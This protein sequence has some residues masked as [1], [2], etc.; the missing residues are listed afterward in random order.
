MNIPD[1]Y[2]ATQ[3]IGEV[4]ERYIDGDEPFPRFIY[5]HLPND[6]MAAARPEDGYPYAESFVAD[7]DY[8]LGRI[9]EFLSRTEWWPKMA[10]F[11]TEDDAQ[12]GRDHVDAHRTVLIAAGPYVKRN[13]VSHVN[14]SFPGLLKT[15]FRILDLPPLNLFDATAS[16]LTDM[17]SSEP[18]LSPYEA[19]PVDARLFIPEEARD[20]LDPLPSLRMDDPRV[21]REQHRR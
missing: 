10:V 19:V 14:S 6:H 15:I 16:D 11:I 12:G 20:P 21:L 2:R 3:F 17:F 4:R 7:N 8:A 9:V 13:Y 5:I 1:Q 18:D